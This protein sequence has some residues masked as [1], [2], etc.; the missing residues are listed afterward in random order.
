MAVFACIASELRSGDIFIDGAQTYSDYRK[1]L[2]QWDLCEPL[3]S[4]FCCDS[5]IPNN[6][7]DFVKVM[8]ERLV[9]L[10]KQIDH[11]YPDIAELII[12]NH[13]IPI[14]KRRAAKKRAPQ[15]TWLAEEIKKCMPERN[16]MD[17][18]CNSHHY[19]EWAQQFGPITG[20]DAKIDNPIERY[21]LTNF[22]YGTRMGPTQTS[23]HQN[24]KTCEI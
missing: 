1:E 24:I 13:G 8:R 9:K 19:T 16:L 4:D 20:F 14:L 23:K 21:I 6:A 2:L 10:S 17:I 15:A 12:D 11:R 3:L 5:G 7:K 22:A 18:L